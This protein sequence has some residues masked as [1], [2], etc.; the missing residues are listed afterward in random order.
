TVLTPTNGT[1]VTPG[2]YPGDCYPT[3]PVAPCVTYSALYSMVFVPA[4]YDYYLSTGDLAFVTQQYAAVTREL[5]WVA[6]KVNSDGLFAAGPAEGATWAL[7]FTASGV[8]ASDNAI[9]YSALV[10]AARLAQAQGLTTDATGY[11]AAA[12]AL[13]T[14][15]NTHFWNPALQ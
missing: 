4:L 10:A 3:D 1:A 11:D 13:K 6:S 15:F 8:S 14:A 2:P 9:Y 5:S 12:A 7:D